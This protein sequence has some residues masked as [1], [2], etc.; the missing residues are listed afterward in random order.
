MEMYSQ[1]T[2]KKRKK[3]TLIVRAILRRD[4]LDDRVLLLQRDPDKVRNAKDLWVLPGGKVD[5]G[6]S[7]KDTCINEVIEETCQNPK[8]VRYLFSQD[9]T[10][11]AGQTFTT[12][13]FSGI[14]KPQICIDQES[15]DSKW[16]SYTELTHMQIAF[17]NGDALTKYFERWYNAMEMLDLEKRKH[18]PRKYLEKMPFFPFWRKIVDPTPYKK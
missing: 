7:P 5:N 12:K 2:D 9:D 8:H 18:V 10:N 11:E 14:I 16:V 13:Y 17:R 6:Y 4:Y 15:K 1:N 3:E